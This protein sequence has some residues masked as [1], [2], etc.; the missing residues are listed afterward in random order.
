[1]KWAALFL[2]VISCIST[3]LPTNEVNAKPFNDP[4]EIKKIVVSC[5]EDKDGELSTDEFNKCV[6]KSLD[7]SRARNKSGT[8]PK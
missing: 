3:A 2:L 6:S 8:K 1:M 4:I 7:F 5:D